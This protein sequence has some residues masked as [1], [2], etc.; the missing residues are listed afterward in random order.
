MSGTEAA[1]AGRQLKVFVSYSRADIDFADQLV[2]ALEDKGFDPILDRHDIDSGEKWKERLG[3]LIFSSDTVVFVLTDTS[4]ASKIC[5]WEV[6]EAARLGKRMIPVVPRSADGV[7]PPPALGELNYIHFYTTPAIPGSGFYDGVQRLCRALNVNLDWLRQQT[8]LAERAAEWR[9]QSAASRRPEDH[10]LRGSTLSEAEH[11]L[12]TAPAGAGIPDVVRDFIVAS[13]ELEGRRNAEALAQIAERESAL[14]DKESAL[15]QKA[16]ADRI[17][18]RATF[19]GGGAVVLL[20]V[21]AAFA[22]WLAAENAADASARRSAL[23]AREAEVLSAEGDHARAMLMALYGD[24]AAQRGWAERLFHAEGYPTTRNALLT[25]YTS[26]RL[27]RTWQAHA[28]GQGVVHAIALSPDGSLVVSAQDQDIRLWSINGGAARAQLT[29]GYPNELEFSRD[30]RFVFGTNENGI[31]VWSLEGGAPVRRIAANLSFGVLALSEDGAT[32]AASTLPTGAVLLSAETGAVL[33]RF[34]TGANVFDVALSDDASQVVTAEQDGVARLWS[35]SGAAI[36]TFG[37]APQSIAQVSAVSF[38]FGHVLTATHLDVKQ[39]NAETGELFQ[40]FEDIGASHLVGDFAL[41]YGVVMRF[42]NGGNFDRPIVARSGGAS[43]MAINDDVIVLGRGDGG[44]DVWHRDWMVEDELTYFMR[45]GAVTD[46]AFSPD[47]EFILVAAPETNEAS[48]HRLSEPR[49]PLVRFPSDG[50]VGAAAYS[51]DGRFVVTGSDDG[52]ARVWPASGGASIAT[53][54][55]DE[56]VVSV[57]FSPDG[58]RVLTGDREGT[59]RVWPA[60]GGAAML[61]LDAGGSGE[62]IPALFSPDGRTIITGVDDVRVWS[63]SDG[64]MTATFDSD[65]VVSLA[66]S[67]DGRLIAAGGRGG[68]IEVW[69]VESGEA[70]RRFRF[71]DIEYDIPM[72]VAFS[73]DDRTIRAGYISG[74]VRVWSLDGGAPIASITAEPELYAAAFSADGQLVAVGGS[75]AGVDI[76]RLPTILSERSA[77]EHVRLACERLREIGVVIVTPAD[78]ERFPILRGEPDSP[79]PPPPGTR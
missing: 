47:G 57:V 17:A 46:L 14:A 53:F 71:D 36:R 8:R 48:I 1:D 19:V 32:I 72:S 39:W 16:R 22:N 13:Q 63:A 44:I 59:V 49:Q 37:H 45:D 18:R 79:C 76:R 10:L 73:A 42:R 7:P 31:L 12:S 29:G 50:L 51:S 33:A 67:H 24:P 61:T 27:L 25:A 77:R 54:E 69:S 52:A 23:F 20:L 55:H 5:Q 62:R 26:N 11:W 58:R 74:R 78:R 38:E 41:N 15:A 65:G 60:N 75:R 43:V 66:Y 34:A 21:V 28:Q 6:E 68:D 56:P 3:A 35:A 64:G 40:E 2:L 9:D 70:L 30:G 4:A